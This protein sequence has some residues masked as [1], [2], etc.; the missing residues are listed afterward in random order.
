MLVRDEQNEIASADATVGSCGNQRKARA[1]VDRKVVL[2]RACA[3]SRKRFER[4]EPS[5]DIVGMRKSWLLRR[6][7]ARFRWVARTDDEFSFGNCRVAYLFPDTDRRRSESDARPSRD[8]PLWPGATGF[9][10]TATL[11]I[12]FD[13]YCEFVH[14]VHRISVSKATQRSPAPEVQNPTLGRMELPCLTRLPR[15]CY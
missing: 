6:C 8:S 12:G 7:R 5:S 1:R 3:D 11:S 10:T 9:F 15:R 14:Q 2:E 13:H 4:R